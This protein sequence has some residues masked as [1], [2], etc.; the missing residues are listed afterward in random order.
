MHWRICNVQSVCGISIF[1]LWWSTLLI[2]CT[3]FTWIILWNESRVFGLKALVLWT[4]KISRK[5]KEWKFTGISEKSNDWWSEKCF[6]QRF[7]VAFLACFLVSCF[8]VSSNFDINSKNHKA[9]SNK[10][11]YEMAGNCQ[12][13]YRDAHSYTKY[14]NFRFLFP[15]SYPC[16]GHTLM[17]LEYVLYKCICT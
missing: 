8:E 11:K 5:L 2:C 4:K 10:H 16:T 3:S 9:T 6:V 12:Y 13:T 7:T 15:I 17:K 1:N 14:G